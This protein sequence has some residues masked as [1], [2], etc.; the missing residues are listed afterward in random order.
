MEL[1]PDRPLC[2][3]TQTQTRP[4]VQQIQMPRGHHGRCLCPVLDGLVRLCL[5]PIQ[6]DQEDT[7]EAPFL[8]GDRSHSSPTKLAQETMVPMAPGDGLRYASPLPQQ[9]GLSVTETTRPRNSVPPGSE[10]SQLNCLE[11]GF[12]NDENVEKRY[13]KMLCS[14]YFQ[15]LWHRMLRTVYYMIILF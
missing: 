13:R 6:P 11:A 14:N 12:S 8:S 1:T 10:V 9:A 15:E 7:P 2:F 5:P 3:L 4:V